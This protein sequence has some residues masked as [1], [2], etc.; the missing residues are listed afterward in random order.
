LAFINYTVYGLD[1]QLGRFWKNRGEDGVTREKQ[2]PIEFLCANASGPMYYRGGDM[3]LTHRGMRISESDW[4]VFLGHTAAALAKF[5]ASEVEQRDVVAR[6]QWSF[7]YR[8]ERLESGRMVDHTL[9]SMFHIGASFSS[10]AIGSNVSS[11]N[12]GTRINPAHSR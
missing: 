5:Q 12:S 4:N 11:T 1:P 10:G 3:V 8:D 7:Q 6:G 9:S 2:L